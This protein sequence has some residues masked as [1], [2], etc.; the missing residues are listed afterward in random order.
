MGRGLLRTPPPPVPVLVNMSD[1]H[2]LFLAHQTDPLFNFKYFMIV[3]FI[4]FLFNYLDD[5][6]SVLY[7]I[8]LFGCC[9]VFIVCAVL[10]LSIESLF[11]LC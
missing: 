1:R 10:P 5:T 7:I 6:E 9:V 8:Y 4:N 3:K 2:F 11:L